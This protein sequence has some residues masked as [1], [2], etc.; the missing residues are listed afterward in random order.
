MRYFSNCARDTFRTL[1]S[2]DLFIFCVTNHVM[3]NLVS[4]RLCTGTAAAP[5]LLLPSGTMTTTQETA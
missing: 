5:G 2:H 1:V 3:F 4:I